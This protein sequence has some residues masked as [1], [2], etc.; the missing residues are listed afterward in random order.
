MLYN[1]QSS[2]SSCIYCNTYIYMRYL[3]TQLVFNKKQQ[4]TSSIWPCH[5]DKWLCE[6]KKNGPIGCTVSAGRLETAVCLLRNMTSETGSP[7]ASCH[8]WSRWSSAMMLRSCFNNRTFPL[9]KLCMPSCR[10][11]FGQKLSIYRAAAKYQLTPVGC[12]P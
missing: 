8:R 11:K 3:V 10:T 1:A 6:W 12:L 4:K 7:V 9:V 2:L 5:W